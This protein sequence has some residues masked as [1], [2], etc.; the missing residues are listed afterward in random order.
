MRFS[1]IVMTCSLLFTLMGSPSLAQGKIYRIG[2]NPSSEVHRIACNRLKL[3]YDRV[4]I[5]VEFVQLPYRRSLSIA[6]DGLIDGDVARIFGIEKEFRNLRRVNVALI[7]FVGVAYINND[8]PS[9]FKEELID[10]MRV[11][12]MR[13][14]LWAKKRL[15]G[16]EAAAEVSNVKSLFDM[17]VAGRID[18]VFVTPSTA[19]AV[20]NNSMDKYNHIHRLYPNLYEAPLYHYVHKDN[21]D[22]IPILEQALQELIQEGYWLE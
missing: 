19:N 5:P 16:R 18:M 17:L 12:I 6:N 1:A 2:Y 22:L 3:A 10:T 15:N 8:E 11:G 14:V 20:L 4:G 9:V 7:K 13:G 21:K